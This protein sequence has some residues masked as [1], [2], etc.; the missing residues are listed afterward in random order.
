MQ[1]SNIHYFF[2]LVLLGVL[3]YNSEACMKKFK[4]A[5]DMEKVS[6][7]CFK[8]SGFREVPSL[9]AMSKPDFDDKVISNRKLWLGTN[10][11]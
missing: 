8:K 10:G 2:G 9:E 6:K 7:E 4:R 5:A 11:L 3:T 1:T